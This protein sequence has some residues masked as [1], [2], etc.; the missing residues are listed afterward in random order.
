M[1]CCLVFGVRT[2]ISIET[3]MLNLYFITPYHYISAFSIQTNITSYNTLLS[4]L[5]HINSQI[6]FKIRVA[7][8]SIY[9]T[10]QDINCTGRLA[11]FI[12][13]CKSHAHLHRTC[14]HTSKTCMHTSRTCIHTSRLHTYLVQ[15]DLFSRRMYMC[16]ISVFS[17]TYLVDVCI[18]VLSQ[19]SVGLI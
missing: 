15:S 2:L 3:M 8:R 17:W 12:Y 1:H 18:C 6:K 10:N 9:K 5:L 19:C 11:W 7:T 16:P 14:I 4:L 13:S